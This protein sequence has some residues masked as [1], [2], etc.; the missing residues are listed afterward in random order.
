MKALSMTQPWA[1]LVIHGGKDV[2]N[3]TWNTKV[4]GRFL[5]HAAKAMP[6]QEYDRAWQLALS[7]SPELARRMPLPGQIERGGI[8]GSVELWDV[9]LPGQPDLM[10]LEPLPMALPGSIRVPPPASR[11]ATFLPLYRSARILERS[12][13]RTTVPKRRR[14]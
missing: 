10:L 11:G 13:A 6:L 3:R 1:W 5:V 12:P 7:L 2:E 14:I 4:R 9:V 8:I